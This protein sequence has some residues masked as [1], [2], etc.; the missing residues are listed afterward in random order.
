MPF[1]CQDEH[2]EN[3]IE[4]NGAD[5]HQGSHPGAVV[6]IINESKPQ[7]SGTAAVRGLDKGTFL[8]VVFHE[9]LRQPPDCE[10]NEKGNEKAE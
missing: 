8:G 6:H 4:G 10:D 3:V 2:S 1:Q 5:D 7:D 9:K